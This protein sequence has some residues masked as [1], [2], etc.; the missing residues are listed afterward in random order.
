MFGSPSG[1][2]VPCSLTFATR[3]GAS[4]SLYVMPVNRRN[5]VLEAEHEVEQ[6]LGMLD[7]PDAH[8]ALDELRLREGFQRIAFSCDVLPEIAGPCGV[9]QEAFLATLVRPSDFRVRQQFRDAL[10][11]LRASVRTARRAISTGEWS[12]TDGPLPK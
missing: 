9:A 8:G 6:I 11:E 3:N 2:G 10:A 5:A 4:P 1:L 7:G 12:A